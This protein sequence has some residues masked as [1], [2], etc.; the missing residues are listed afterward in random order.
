MNR[1]GHVGI[2]SLAKV[3]EINTAVIFFDMRG[4]SARCALRAAKQS[5][6][7]SR[8]ANIVNMMSESGWIIRKHLVR[9]QAMICNFSP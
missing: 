8:A 9:N 6:Q 5:Q 4:A 7:Q 1:I 3:L 2:Q